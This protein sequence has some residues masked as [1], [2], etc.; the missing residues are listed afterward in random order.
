MVCEFLIGFKLKFQAFGD[1]IQR[2]WLR[3]YSNFKI[4]LKIPVKDSENSKQ[5][6]FKLK[7]SNIFNALN[8]KASISQSRFNN[9]NLQKLFKI[10]WVFKIKL[11]I[12]ELTL[13]TNKKIFFLLIHNQS[14][15]HQ[16]Q[17]CPTKIHKLPEFFRFFLNIWFS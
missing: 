15:S 14:L 2:L 9:I 5:K 6:T 3:Y 12:S 7:V 1:I 16:L 8:F 11:C 17:K 10:I 4:K 13:P